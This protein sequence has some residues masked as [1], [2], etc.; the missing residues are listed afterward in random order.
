MTKFATSTDRDA[1]RVPL[2]GDYPFRTKR[3]ITFTGA[4]GSNTWGDDG[5]TLDG[6]VIFT[7]TG[8]V[9]MKLIA[10]CTTLLDSDGAAT[11]SV[12]I[13]GATAIFLPVETATQIDAGQIWVNDASNVTYIDIGL[14][15][16]T[17]GNLPEYLLN[18]ND[19]IMTIAGG[20]NVTA[21]TL[22]FYALWKPISDDVSV[23]AT[24][25]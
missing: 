10:A 16:A 8:L 20:A 15:S 19:I 6:G 21:G 23:V 14:E 4:A 25:T 12:G 17:T 18:G 1:N 24:T 22:D 7:V 9:T 3:S 5:G 2:V 13:T 11:L